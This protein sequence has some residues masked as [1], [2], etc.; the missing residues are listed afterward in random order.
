MPKIST[1]PN[2]LKLRIEE[3]HVDF[4][5]FYDTNKPIIFNKIIECFN[6]L[7]KN[8]NRENIKLLIVGKISGFDWDTE[9]IFHKNDQQTLI[10]D[11]LPFF[12]QI[13]DY[14]T[15]SEIIKLHKE[16]VK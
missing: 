10:K 16:L 15:C 8:P 13:E 5:N 14:E 11:I 7:I 6:I 9:F 4:K 1:N 3:N 12:E 2:Q